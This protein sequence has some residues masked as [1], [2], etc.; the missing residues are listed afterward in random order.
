MCERDIP[1]CRYILNSICIWII[2]T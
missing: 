2:P 1:V